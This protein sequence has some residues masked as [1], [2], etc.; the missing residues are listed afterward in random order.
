MS[1]PETCAL[2]E[3]L[4]KEMADQGRLIEAGWVGLKVL[5]LNKETPQSV[6]DELHMAFMAGAQ[7]LFSS[8]MTILSPGEEI[9]DKDLKVMDLISQ[10]LDAYSAELQ[11][12]F[13]S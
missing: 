10:E 7:H 5:T 11:R 9:T 12:R 3:R 1:T 13:P 8:I 6:E 4:T 2:A